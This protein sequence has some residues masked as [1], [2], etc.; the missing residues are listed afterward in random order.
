ML[1]LDADQIVLPEFLEEN[2]GFFADPEVA[3][4]QTPQYFINIPESD[5]YCSR[6]DLF[7]GP[8]QQGKDGW[9]AAFFCGSNAIL[10]RVTLLHMGLVN[11]A[12]AVSQHGIDAAIGGDEAVPLRP[13][14]TIS[15]TEDMATCQRMHALGWKTIFSPRILAVGLAPDDW[16]SAVGQKLRWAQGTIQVLLRENPLT[17]H[18]PKGAVSAQAY[19]NSLYPALNLPMRKVGLRLTQR[20]NYLMTMYSYLSGPFMLIQLTAPIVYLTTGIPPVI[21]YTAPYFI[22]LLPFLVL[23]RI[24]F[25][26]VAQGIK[27]WRAEQHNVALFPLWIK[28]LT[29][30]INNVLFGRKLGF[31]VTP[32]DGTTQRRDFANLRTVWPQ[33]VY[34]AATVFA[35]VWGLV[36]VIHGDNRRFG[37]LVNCFWAMYN[38][39]L[40]SAAPYA[41]L[42]RPREQQQTTQAA[43]SK[44]ATVR[45]L[46]GVPSAR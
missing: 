4:V 13:F 10:R 25:L 43:K 11:F 5:P 45:T 7:Y 28:A 18:P 16:P 33:L 17:Y 41:A 3:L 14:A 35:I 20:L 38:I 31:V 27:T 34:I 24:V 19:L 42:W 2:L 6:P 36:L 39:A 23:N 8:I 37:I 30:A 22:R 1:I 44:A 21:S 46:Q 32:K 26:I 12:E 29:S 40:L 15:V 9:N